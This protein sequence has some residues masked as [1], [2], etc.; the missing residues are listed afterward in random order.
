[1]SEATILQHLSRLRK[2]DKWLIENIPK[3]QLLHRNKERIKQYGHIA[4]AAQ[5]KQIIKMYFKHLE[6][7]H[8]ADY[9]QHIKAAIQYYLNYIGAEENIIL[10]PTLN[11]PIRKN[12]RDRAKTENVL[13]DQDILVLRH[14]FGSSKN[15]NAK[16]DAAIFE[17]LVQLGIR[18]HELLLLRT[19]DFSIKKNQVTIRSTKTEGKSRYG[20]QRMMPLTRDLWQIVKKH[21]SPDI[22]PEE[23][24]FNT[25]NH[26]IWR[27]IKAAGKAL[28]L[29]WIRPHLLR[30]YCITRF[31]QQT[32]DDGVSPIFSWKE[33]SL[34]FGVSPEVIAARYDHP[35]TENIISKALKSKVYEIS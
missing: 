24:I 23:T 8:P 7:I 30:H 33:L 14:Y 21:V 10:T 13:S 19:V 2:F 4:A 35:S 5:Q 6:E 11:I 34:M 16:R 29:P 18:V 3:S 31:S 26:Q 12:G 28:D 9:R 32:G 17:C 25:N 22:P 27:I 20:G 15:D 1:M